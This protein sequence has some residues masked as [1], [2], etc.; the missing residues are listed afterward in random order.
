MAPLSSLTKR[1][2]DFASPLHS[3]VCF[4]Q[5]GFFLRRWPLHGVGDTALWIDFNVSLSRRRANPVHVVGRVHLLDDLFSY[6]P[7]GGASLPAHLGFLF[8]AR[9]T[10]ELAL[11][12]DLTWP[13]S[14]AAVEEFLPW[15]L[16]FTGHLNSVLKDLV[17]RHEALSEY[18]LDP[19]SEGIQENHVSQF[20]FQVKP[21]HQEGHVAKVA[22]VGVVMSHADSELEDIFGDYHPIFA[23]S[24]GL[25][26]WLLKQGPYIGR[27]Q[28]YR[29]HWIHLALIVDLDAHE[30]ELKCSFLFD[31][32]HQRA[33]ALEIER[34]ELL[35]WLAYRDIYFFDKRAQLEH[36]LLVSLPFCFLLFFDLGVLG[37]SARGRDVVEAEDPGVTVCHETHVDRLEVGAHIEERNL[38][39]CLV[40]ALEGDRHVA[41]HCL[42][43][44]PRVQCLD[45]ERSVLI[46]AIP[47]G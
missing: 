46:P 1:A 28:S 18:L 36:D 23:L 19:V 7:L 41:H 11:S 45:A 15:L 10:V 22:Y 34:Q 31:F 24:T 43:L 4:L 32:G 14:V 17:V 9:V 26:W 30:V 27:L 25:P 16:L 37:R 13:S 47:R 20:N 38:S 2:C 8:L 42:D 6:P 35:A 33:D 40:Q 5:V 29:V 3:F 12:D 44:I 39:F 21:L